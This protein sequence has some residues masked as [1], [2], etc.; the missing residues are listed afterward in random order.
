MPPPSSAPLV[1]RSS[2]IGMPSVGSLGPT[3]AMQPMQANRWETPLDSAWTNPAFFPPGTVLVDPPYLNPGWHEQAFVGPRLWNRPNPFLM[4]Q[5]LVNPLLLNR[6]FLDPVG[7]GWIVGGGWGVPVGPMRR[8]A[9]EFAEARRP[10]SLSEQMP[11]FPRSTSPVATTIYQ[12][13]SGFVTLADGSTF[14]RA[15]G[16]APSTEL[17][18]YS[19][20]GGLD[21]SLIGGNFFSPSLGTGGDVSRVGTFLPY[22]W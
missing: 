17:G 10:G 6:P 4:N 11:E 13:L 1:K 14:Y 15:G 7:P 19:T 8:H 21:S 3:K 20:G 16:T 5:L 12:P 18:N 9:G 22:V 2:I